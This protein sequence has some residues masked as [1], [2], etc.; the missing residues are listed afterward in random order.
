LPDEI[1]YKFILKGERFNFKREDICIINQHLNKIIM[2]TKNLYQIVL[3]LSLTF[4]IQTGFVSFPES[5]SKFFEISK[6]GKPISAE[7]KD[8]LLKAYR[9]QFGKN[10]KI[11]TIEFVESDDLWLVFQSGG[12]GTSTFTIKTTVKNGAVGFGSNSVTNTCSGNPCSWCYFD[13]AVGCVCNKNAAG[14]CNHTQTSLMEFS[15]FT[16]QLGI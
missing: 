11:Q 12:E 1:I 2:K 9:A 6:E 10:S 3:L 13:G 16:A 8:L 4:I 7:K 15:R 14:T 5:S